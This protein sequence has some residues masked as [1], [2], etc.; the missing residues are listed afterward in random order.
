MKINIHRH[1][2]NPRAWGS[3]TKRGVTLIEVMVCMAALALIAAGLYNGTEAA[4]RGS[5][6]NAMHVSAYGILQ[7]T[8]EQMRG[9]DFSSISVANYPTQTVSITTLG[10]AKATN[11]AYGTFSCTVSNL[12][13]PARKMVQLSLRWNYRN[14]TN[15]TETLSGCIVDPN[16]TASLMGSLT[17]YLYLNPNGGSPLQFSLTQLGGGTITWSTLTNLPKSGSTTYTASDL[18]VQVGGAGHREGDA[19]GEEQIAGGH[20]P[21][22]PTRQR[23]HHHLGDQIGGLD[24]AD[25]IGRGRDAGLN[26]GDGTGDDLDVQNR[27]EHAQHHGQE[28]DPV[29]WRDH[30]VLG[31]EGGS[32]C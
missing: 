14:L 27:H 8:F 3:I 16:A 24:P 10:G 23:N 30:P 32:H 21:R 25:F 7:N 17:G 31:A 12:A 4:T 6:I 26:L 5:T 22:Q 28:S 19:G 18:L 9:G 1:D 2:R 15:L 29:A 20:H 11:T 13:A